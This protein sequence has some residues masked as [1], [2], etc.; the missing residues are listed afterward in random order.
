[1]STVPLSRIKKANIDTCTLCNHRCV[2]C[3]SHQAR[4]L[5]NTLSMDDFR[6][7]LDQVCGQAAISELGLSAKGEPLLNKDLE[8]MVALAKRGRK[9]PYVYISTNGALLH[10]PRLAALLDAGLDSV[11]FSINAFDREG[12]RRVHGRDDFD[13][14]L[15][16]LGLAIE[17]K[18]RRPFR[19]LVSAVT[20]LPDRVIRE[21]LEALLG[22]GIKALDHIW[23]Y[24]R[25]YMPGFPEPPAPPDAAYRP[26]P[27]IFNEIYVD[28]NCDLMACCVD[29][30]GELR[31]GNLK[32]RPLS[33]LWAGPGFEALRRMHRERSL[34]EG[35]MCRL[36]LTHSF[37]TQDK[38]CLED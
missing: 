32:D 26:C 28:A 14:V 23:H 21:R 24:G 6:L 37:R 17:E 29:Y 19:I 2:F 25:C 9:I 27:L 5:K 7:V 36:C 33:E 8:D 15:E 22:P 20:E 10:G 30:F 12:Y 31:F 34:P 4:A 18:S 3:P 13:L 1:M 35:H 16:N 38:T 11:K